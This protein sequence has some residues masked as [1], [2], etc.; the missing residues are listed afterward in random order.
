MNKVTYPPLLRG[1]N[2]TMNV[3]TLNEYEANVIKNC[4]IDDRGVAFTRLGS[5]LLNTTALDGAVTSIYN[6]N[7]PYGSTTVNTVLVTA[8]DILYKLN[9]TTDTFDYVH[10]LNTTARP[11]WETFQD[12]SG[13]AYAILANGHD[14]IKYDG[15][16]VT[17]VDTTGDYPW[18]QNPR[19]LKAYGDRLLASGCDS[20]PSTVWV[21]DTLDC[22]EWKPSGSA[23]YWTA[24]GQK[25]DRVT[26]LGGVYNFGVIFK[27]FSTDI[28]TE[29]DP[30]STTAE[31]ITVSSEYGTTSHWSILNIGNILY[32]CD[33]SHIYKGILRNAI[34]NGLEVKPIDNNIYDIYRTVENH[35]DIVSAYDAE[36]QEIQ[37]GI[38]TKYSITS[39]KSVVYNI[40][41]SEAK[42]ELGAYDVWSGWFEGTG[43]EPYTLSAV[44]TSDSG[45]KIYRGD[46]LGYVYV[47]EESFQ[48]KDQKRVAGVTTD[49]DVPVKITPAP[50][51]PYG[52]TVRKMARMFMPYVSQYTDASIKIQWIVDG[53]YVLPS[54]DKYLVLY[55]RVPY[56]RASTKTYQKQVWSN[57]VYTDNAVMPRPIGIHE[58]FQY[59]MFNIICDGTND[60]D[61]ITYNGSELLYQ[62]HQ[63]SR[64]KG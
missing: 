27:Q 39:D 17:G 16:T 55:N 24:R 37:F 26:G 25:G 10:P 23:L 63:P 14:F 13:T 38:R 60:K 6:F 47:M 41:L 31:Q 11:S 8:G 12:S 1:C 40:G 54:T 28:I 36:H 42:G 5:R 52:I 64:I 20:D 9:D 19:Y 48:K 44:Y 15:T 2:T 51:K 4:H 35:S 49:Y 53:S 30:G 58:P 21:S 22:T 33:E 57:T 59:I 34:E 45:T 18:A 43:Y 29:G 61:F 3:L 62:V 32:F 56:W 50:F 46:S 7:R